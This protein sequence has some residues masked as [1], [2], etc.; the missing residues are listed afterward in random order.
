MA[1]VSSKP[2]EKPHRFKP[3]SFCDSTKNLLIFAQIFGVMPVKF[4]SIVYSIIVISSCFLLAVSCFITNITKKGFKFGQI[5]DVFF[6][7]VTFFVMIQFLILAKKSKWP[8]IMKEW[9]NVEEKLYTNK[10]L[11]KKVRKNLKVVIGVVLLVSF[12]EF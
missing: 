8:T 5:S 11:D 10:D 6:Y 7:S 3:Q 9:R 4:Y 1:R 12:S 2:D